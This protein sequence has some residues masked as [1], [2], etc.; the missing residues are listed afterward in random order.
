MELHY[1]YQVDLEMLGYGLWSVILITCV[2][3]LFG[4]LCTHLRQLDWYQ[5]IKTITR[6]S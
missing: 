1:Q 2:A 6:N 4:Q 5:L 3:Y